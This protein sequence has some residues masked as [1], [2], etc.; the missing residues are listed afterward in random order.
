MAKISNNET[1]FLIK[2]SYMTFFIFAFINLCNGSEKEGFTP[3]DSAFFEYKNSIFTI[4][5]ENFDKINKPLEGE[6]IN[7]SSAKVTNNLGCGTAT[8]IDSDGQ[9]FKAISV[10]HNFEDAGKISFGHIKQGLG[11]Y[12][13]Y[14]NE[15][16]EGEIEK[17]CFSHERDL[18][19]LYGSYV[20]PKEG[21]SKE[22]IKNQ[23]AKISEECVNEPSCVFVYTLGGDDQRY[24]EGMVDCIKEEHFISTQPG[25]SGLGIFSKKT[26]RLTGVHTGSTRN[27]RL[28]NVQLEG[29]DNPLYVYS[30][31]NFHIVTKDD[32]QNEFKTCYNKKV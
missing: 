24:K 21:I 5:K 13:N 2:K 14:Y 20:N 10:K 22:Q 7:L 30:S 16:I 11:K 4:S 28:K 3:G 27:K 12:G 18:A 9:K 1:S 23:V 26:G 32:I 29:E 31:N 19:L 8:I 25:D 17:V 15:L 6:E